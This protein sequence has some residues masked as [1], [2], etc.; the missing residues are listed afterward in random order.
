VKHLHQFDQKE[1]IKLIE[2]KPMKMMSLSPAS[3]EALPFEMI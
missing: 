1:E 2:M 3:V